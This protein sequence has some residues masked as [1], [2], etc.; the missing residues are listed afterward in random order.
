VRDGGDIGEVDAIAGARRDADEILGLPAR[1]R[2]ADLPQD[3][4][5]VSTRD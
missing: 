1:Q 5:E 4:D 3:G 2:R